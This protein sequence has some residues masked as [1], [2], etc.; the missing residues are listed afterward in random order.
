VISAIEHDAEHVV[1]NAPILSVLAYFGWNFISGKTNC[2]NLLSLEKKQEDKHSG[3]YRAE[4]TPTSLGSCG[5]N[6]SSAP[7]QLE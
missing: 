2:S 1:L 6:A 3:N 4:K 7:T 5:E